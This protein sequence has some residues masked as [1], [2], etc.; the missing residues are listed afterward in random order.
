MPASNAPQNKQACEN[1]KAVVCAILRDY[2]HK[3]V[4]STYM[5]HKKDT[6]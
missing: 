3:K 1:K 5:P 2:T 4:H 6:L